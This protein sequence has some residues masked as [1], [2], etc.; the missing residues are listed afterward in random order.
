MTLAETSLKGGLVCGQ[1][2]PLPPG[3]RQPLSVSGLNTPGPPY[4]G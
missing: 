1:Y 4:R 3:T 2:M